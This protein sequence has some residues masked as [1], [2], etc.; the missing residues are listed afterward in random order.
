MG[1]RNFRDS[2]NRGWEVWLVVPTA[3]ERRKKER[4]AAIGTSAATY[5]GPERR[6]TPRRLNPF[7]RSF[8]V[9]ARYEHGW[10]CFESENGEKRR[11]APVPDDWEA[12]SSERLE[13]WCRLA[14]RVVK[15]GPAW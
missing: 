9:P 2:E 14:V 3:A 5:S 12:S 10:L 8:A 6:I 7:R 15:C 4:R 13:V 11:L 1:Y